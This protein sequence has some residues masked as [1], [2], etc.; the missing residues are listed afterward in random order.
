MKLTRDYFAQRA[1]GLEPVFHGADYPELGDRIEHSIWYR[2]EPKPDAAAR[3]TG[4]APAMLDGPGHDA[5]GRVPMPSV[6]ALAATV[7]IAAGAACVAAALWML[8]SRSGRPAVAPLALVAG[9]VLLALPWALPLQPGR[10]D[11]ASR[12][13]TGTGDDRRGLDFGR[14]HAHGRGGAA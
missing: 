5:P 13:R 12:D 4:G 14:R 10:P 3:R 11:R 6:A 7:A 9:A 1:A 8:V 2:D